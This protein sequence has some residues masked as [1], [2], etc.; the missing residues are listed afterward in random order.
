MDKS[1]TPFRVLLLGIGTVGGAVLRILSQQRQ[2]EGRPIEVIAIMSHNAVR[3][4]RAQ[5]PEY[6]RQLA[7]QR[8]F[9]SWQGLHEALEQDTRFGLPDAVIELMGGV[10]H[11]LPIYRYF[12][13]RGISVITANKALLAECGAELFPLARQCGAAIACEASCGGGIPI[14]QSLLGGLRANRIHEFYGVLNGTCNFILSQMAAE[15]RSYDEVLRQAQADGLAESDPFL[16][17]SG[18]DTA[19]KLAILAM[20]SFGRSLRLEDIP[21]CGIA[22]LDL[23]RIRVARQLGFAT[24]L[25]ASARLPERKSGLALRVGPCL[26]PNVGLAPLSP[27][28]SLEGSFNG[29]SFYGDN[30]GHIYLEGRGAGASATASAVLGDLC[31]LKNGSYA[32]AFADFP[33][34]PKPERLLR[35]NCWTELLQDWLIFSSANPGGT[36]SALEAAMASSPNA[37]NAEFDRLPGTQGLCVWQLHNYSARQLQEWTN[38]ISD[39]SCLPILRVPKEQ[40]RG[41]LGRE[42]SGRKP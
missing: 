35:E 37:G 5:A 33:R 24:K 28:G 8:L 29:I 3:R 21:I 26:I 23:A 1:R 36:G 31:Q 6:L 4:L 25:L 19:H 34:W 18:T 22:N 39:L 17:V 20:L 10:E 38:R 14:L 41:E 42:F 30:V 7:P 27:L 40:Q 32:L 11:C 15:D 16:D 9:D 13:R 2:E 12:L